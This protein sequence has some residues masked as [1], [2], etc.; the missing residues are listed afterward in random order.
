MLLGGIIAPD[1][2][3]IGEVDRVEAIRKSCLGPLTIGCDRPVVASKGDSAP[4]E[5][6]LHET[7]DAEERF[8]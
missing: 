4:N 5:E 8:A 7:C 3:G 2:F 6:D 1:Y